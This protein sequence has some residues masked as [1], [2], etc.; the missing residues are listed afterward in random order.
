[1]VLLI[2]NELSQAVMRS[3]RRVVDTKRVADVGKPR[4]K[5]SWAHVPL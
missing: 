5:V 3:P 2:I 4:I 1:M